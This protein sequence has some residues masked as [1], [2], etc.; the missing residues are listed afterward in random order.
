MGI[1]VKDANRSANQIPAEQVGSQRAKRQGNE[2]RVE[3]QPEQPA[4]PGAERG[5]EAD[6]EEIERGELVQEGHS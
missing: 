2:Q 1:Q 5:T 4:H 3:K 6:G